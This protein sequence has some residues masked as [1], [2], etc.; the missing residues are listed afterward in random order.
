MAP[1]ALSLERYKVIDFAGYIGGSFDGILGKYPKTK[2][3][4]TSTLDVFS[5]QV[6]SFFRNTSTSYSSEDN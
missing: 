1:V 2:I 4:F 3:S 5:Y 6:I